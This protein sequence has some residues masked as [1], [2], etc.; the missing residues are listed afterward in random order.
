MARKSCNIKEFS[1]KN[2]VF[3]YQK[4][5]IKNV[6]LRLNEKGKFYLS[7]PYFYTL[8]DIEKFLIKHED[9][10]KKTWLNFKNKTNE[11][12]Q[13]YFLGKKYR[14]VLKENLFKTKILKTEIHTPSRIEF[15]SFL[16][17]NS[18]I[19]FLFYLKK[20]TQRTKLNYTH[21][22]IKKMKTRWGSC[23]HKKGYINLNLKL[24]EKSLKAIEYVI[25]HEIAHLKYPNHSQDFYNFLA[26]YM[27]DFR[28]REK[29]FKL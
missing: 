29:E 16:R 24:L 14:L 9:W 19:I 13:V 12:D 8:D 3:F 28:V 17:K 22:S 2:W 4:K 27:K 23:N 10:I 6:Y 7:L 1:W 5:S 21:L 20:W 18:K 15:E 11:V 25:L 26:F